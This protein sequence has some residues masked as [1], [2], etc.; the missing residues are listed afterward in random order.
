VRQ[1]RWP[2]FSAAAKAWP[3]SAFSEDSD[4]GIPNTNSGK[5]LVLTP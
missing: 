3:R 5:E 1:T 4:N 2:G